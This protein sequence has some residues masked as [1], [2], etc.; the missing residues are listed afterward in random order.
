MT[1]RVVNVRPLTS[2]GGFLYVGRRCKHPHLGW[3][4]GHPLANP[5]KVGRGAGAQAKQACLARYANWLEEQLLTEDGQRCFRILA[6]VAA[7]R[8]LP[9]GCWCGDWDGVSEPA[10]LCHA[11]VLAKRCSA[12][13]EGQSQ[14]RTA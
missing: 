14:A 12:W 3:L 5:F 1:V 13:L 11:V 10:P 8:N 7:R 4:G 6:Q 2:L 9:L